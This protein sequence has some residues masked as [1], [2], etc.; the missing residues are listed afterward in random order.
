[1]KDYKGVDW[2]L[3]AITVLATDGKP[4]QGAWCEIDGMQKTPF[5]EEQV[6]DAQGV[7]IVAVQSGAHRYVITKMGYISAEG[8]LDNND[9]VIHLKEE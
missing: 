8:T 6:T 3:L 7:F 1:M 9:I 5:Y 4:I 2:I